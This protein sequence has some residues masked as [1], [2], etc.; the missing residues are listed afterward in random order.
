[1]S[2]EVERA[3]VA[4]ERSARPAGG[5]HAWIASTDHKRLGVNI[6]VTTLLFFLAGGVL[7][8]IMRLELAAPG[9]QVVSKDHYDQIFTMHGS[10]MIYLVVQPLALGLGVYLVPL[11]IGAP[12]IAA[13]RAVLL[14]LW[15]LIASGVMMYAG[16]ATSHGAAPDGWTAFLPLSSQAFTPGVGMDMWVVGVILSTAGQIAW[17]GAILATIL[18]RRAPGMTLMRMPVFTWTQVVTCL[19][20][21]FSFPV[22]IAAMTLIL[23]AR[24][25]TGHVIDPVLYL[26]LFWFFGHPNVYVMFFPYVGAVGEV[27]ATFSGRRFFGYAAFVTS[28]FAF[29]V[30]SMSVWAHHMFTTGQSF[31]EYFALTSTALAVVA[32]IEYFDM[33]GTMIGGRIVLRVPMLFAIFFLVQFLVG[34]LTGIIIASPPL[35]Y[36]LNDSFFIVAHFHYTLFAGSLFGFFAGFYYWFP[37][38]TGFLLREGL[39][40]VHFWLLVLGTNLTFMPMFVS[41]Y[42]G[43]VRRAPDY[44]RGMGLEGPNIASTVGAFVIALSILA[45]I[46]NLAVSSARRRA[47]GDDPWGGQSLEWATSSPPPRFNFTRLP[48][49]RSY[50]P[51]LDLRR[52]RLEEDGRAGAVAAAPATEAPP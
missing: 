21:L 12:A 37:K 16:F 35:D 2:A 38:A 40:K 6:V 23:I 47:A 20:V 51:L 36:H 14:G 22:L 11:Q 43:Q 49:V 5:A 41:G 31:N 39:G 26:H 3:T 34:G 45:L 24:H 7:A 9:Q 46:A 19:M 28:L 10:T 25:T 42:E 32:G 8:L 30:L 33:I 4:A 17:A 13:A 52:D 29:T 27:I 1:V 44:P 50:A 15:L 48:P 18:R